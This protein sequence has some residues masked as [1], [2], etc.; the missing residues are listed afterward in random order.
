MTRSRIALGESKKMLLRRT[1]T[2]L[3]TMSLMKTPPSQKKSTRKRAIK[4]S[5]TE[6]NLLSNFHSN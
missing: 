4:N 1:R 6:T 3:K 2:I 5:L